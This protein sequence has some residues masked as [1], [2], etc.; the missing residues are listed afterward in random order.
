MNTDDVCCLGLAVDIG[1]ISNQHAVGCNQ[2]KQEVTSVDKLLSEIICN[3]HIILPKPLGA[4]ASVT[5]SCSL[6][7]MQV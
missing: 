5:Y 2:S 3:W 7:V 4:I 1:E 6:F